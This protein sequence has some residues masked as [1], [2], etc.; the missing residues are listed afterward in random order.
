MKRFVITV[1]FLLAL[2]GGNQSLGAP[3]RFEK[4]SDH[5][6][7]LQLKESGDNVAVVVTDEG[8][9]VVDP[10]SEPDLTPTVAALKRV[11]LKPVRWVVF[12]N[13]RSARSGGGQFFAEQGAVLLGGAKLRAISSSLAT[14]D[15]GSV[16]GDLSAF[17][18]LIFDTQIHLFPAN[19]EIRIMALQHKAITGG[20]VVVHIPAEKVLFAGRVYESARYPEIDTAAHGD[21]DEWVDGLKQVIDSVPVL[22]PAIPQ[23]KV[24]PKT[25]PEK[26]LEE[27]IVVLSARGEISNL[28]IAKDLLSASQKLRAEIVKVVKAGRSCDNFINSSRADGYRL[29]GNFNA[30]ATQLCESLSSASNPGK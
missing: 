29:Y 23:A 19:M 3:L 20:D 10:P 22:K 17:P 4:V 6:Y 27:G 28:Q 26:T 9:L 15:T 25:E 14:P 18:W 21:A 30:Y 11:S 2:W 12:S 24:N 16:A 7:Y 8:I 5:C 1:F 13:P